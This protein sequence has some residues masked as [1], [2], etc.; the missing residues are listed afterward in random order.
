MK[1]C[2]KRNME[3]INKIDLDIALEKF[4]FNSRN[5]P[6]AT[7][8]K[9]PSEVMFNRTIRTTWDLIKLQEDKVNE[10][11]RN[12]S[13]NR[14][15]MNDD[16]VWYKTFKGNMWDKDTIKRKHGNLTFEVETGDKIIRRHL[17]QIKKRSTSSA[18]LD[19]TTHVK[20]NAILYT[21]SFRRNDDPNLGVQ[22]QNFKNQSAVKS[23]SQSR[24]EFKVKRNGEIGSRLNSI[25]DKP[26]IDNIS[27]MIHDIKS[28]KDKNFN[29][30]NRN[31]NNNYFRLDNNFRNYYD[32][33]DNN[34][35]SNRNRNYDNNYIFRYY[36][37]NNGNNN[38][39]YHDNYNNY[40]YNNY[41]YSNNNQSN[42]GRNDTWHEP[43]KNG[44]NNGNCN[45]YQSYNNNSNNYRGSDNSQRKQIQYNNNSNN[46]RGSDNSQR[47][48]IQ[49]NNNDHNMNIEQIIE[50][51]VDSTKNKDDNDFNI[52]NLSGD[53]LNV[54]DKAFITTLK[55]NDVIT[56]MQV[57][58]GSKHTIIPHGL[59]EKLGI[60][61][62]KK[63]EL[64]L[65]AYDGNLIKIINI[66]QVKV[67]YE[68]ISKYLQAAV[69]ESMKN[70]LLGCTW[71]NAFKN[72]L[73]KFIANI[74]TNY[75]ELIKVCEC[76]LTNGPINKASVKLHLKKDAQPKIIPPRGIPYSKIDLVS[77]EL[78]KWIH[79]N[80]IEPGYY[81]FT[82][83]PFGLKTSSAIFQQIM[84][85]IS[86]DM[87]DV[88]FYIDDLLITGINDETLLNNIKK[89]L[90]RISSFGLVP[91]F[92]KRIATD[93]SKCGLGA[94][95]FHTEKFGKGKPIAFA[96]LY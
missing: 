29:N 20:T 64:Q 28:D 91:N 80:I 5:T 40:N 42:Y 87:E 8:N 25:N 78:K 45:N 15:I 77:N 74:D 14:N 30:R 9:I 62:V 71:I 67:T 10:F 69:V 24:H 76:K 44:S 34:Y 11:N 70:A 73:N 59:A 16:K 65:T 43:K 54:K 27:Y 52:N 2:M 56:T 96:E 37:R 83:L 41:R 48:Q 79:D 63:S 94:V 57:D 89:V 86:G 38:S 46:Y 84:D 93:A 49:Y 50:E 18:P 90:D 32:N 33:R 21:V 53:M 72:I 26:D 39:R 58:T 60:R 55:V 36:D 13:S 1:I 81:R 19:E 88:I 82:R 4:S 22:E 17:D 31:D 68:G 85:Q 35:N 47:K 75:E 23:R 3:S 7:T 6:N 95:L 66:T 12:L 51:K 92:N 61:N